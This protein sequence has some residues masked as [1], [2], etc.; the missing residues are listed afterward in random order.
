MAFD[1]Q[2]RFDHT[3][4][5]NHVNEQNQ[6]AGTAQN[7][8]TE[9]SGLYRMTREDLKNST[10]YTDTDRRSLFIPDIKHTSVRHFDAGIGNEP[11]SIRVVSAVGRVVCDDKSML[12]GMIAKTDVFS[13]DISSVHH[14]LTQL[15][16]SSEKNIGVS[17]EGKTL[18]CQRAV[19]KEKCAA[20]GGCVF[21]VRQKIFDKLISCISST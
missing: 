21:I 17:R 1:E 15:T 14:D 16:A 5:D 8:G 7:E 11:F 12:G 10:L 20:V 2:D 9:G 4:T 6:T 3:E 19:Q 13:A 18:V